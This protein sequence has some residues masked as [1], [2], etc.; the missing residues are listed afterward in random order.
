MDFNS[1]KYISAL[2][3]TKVGAYGG[4]HPY[5]RT[6]ELPRVTKHELN[7]DAATKT[8]KVKLTVSKP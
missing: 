6:P 4:Q 1:T 5:S 7:I 8:M 3:G 2:D